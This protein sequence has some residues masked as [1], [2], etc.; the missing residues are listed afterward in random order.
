MCSSATK[1]AVVRRGMCALRPLTCL[2]GVDRRPRRLAIEG[3]LAYRVAEQVDGVDDRAIALLPVLTHEFCVIGDEEMTKTDVIAG[4]WSGSDTTRTDESSEGTYRS[5]PVGMLREPSRPWSG[6]WR[7]HDQVVVG[8]LGGRHEEVVLCASRGRV[9]GAAR[10]D[11]PASCREE[12]SP[13]HR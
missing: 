11:R 7:P 5:V 3:A 10:N 9:F 6:A 8:S 4:P 13:Q 1:C 2:L 12:L